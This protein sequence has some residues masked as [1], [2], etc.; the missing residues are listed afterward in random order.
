MRSD[1]IFS[2]LMRAANIAA[3]LGLGIL[4]A[5][6]LGPAGKG[7]YALPMV[8]AGLVGTAFVGLSSAT[9]YALLNQHAGRSIVRTATLAAVIFTIGG[10]LAIAVVALATRAYWAAPAAI[11]SLP[12]LA[13]ANVVTGYVTG[14]KRIRYASTILTATTACTLA[15]MAL[16]FYFVA[17]SAWVAIGV[18][19][20]ASTL[21]AIVAYAAMLWHAR[22]LE[23]GVR[24]DMRG[25][26]RL[27]TKVGATS[28]VTLLNYRADL[29]IVAVL[30]SPAA[31]GIYTVAV[32]AAES[33]LL[34]TQ[35][36]ALVASPHIGSLDKPLAANLAARCVRNNLLIAIVACAAL[37]VLAPLLVNLLY[38]PSFAPVVT[39]M[40]ILLLGVVALSLGSPVSSYYTLRLGKPEIPL[41]LA[42][43]S[44]AVCI[45]TT[46]VLIPHLGLIGAAI[47]STVA[48]VAGQGLGLG[49][50]ARLTGLRWNAMLVPTP[51]DL[52][53]Y[54]DFARRPRAA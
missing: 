45:V 49:Y 7:V 19:I 25:Y 17:R 31:L 44:A 23:P 43:A 27:A 46:I 21:V 29:Y 53:V 26:L 42:G 5:R 10:G 24:V 35:V 37:F 20:A 38:G 9:T 8:Q 39:P 18:W 47:G 33:L 13:A 54:Y 41:V 36:C 12:A 50:F 15:L 3:A 14:I 22:K 1:A 28:L 40:R 34:P 52:R 11:A 2:L 16:G 48:Y 32:S 30:L 4:T 6:L 51:A